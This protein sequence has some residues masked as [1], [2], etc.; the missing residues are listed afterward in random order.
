M[1]YF[2][3][4]AFCFA[5]V[6]PSRAQSSWI[7]CAQEAAKEFTANANKKVDYNEMIRR[8]QSLKTCLSGKPMPDF[9][10]TSLDG[11]IISPEDIKGKVVLV[12]F[13]FI[14]CAPCV[15]EIPM[16][17]EL[18]DEYKDC[19]FVIL[20]FSRDSK[21]AIDEF[22][23][24]TP[25]NFNVFASSSKLIENTFGVVN[26]YPT[27]ILLNKKGFLV[28]YSTGGAV[29][30]IGIARTKEKMRQLIEDQLADK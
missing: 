19:G 15:K 28:E 14:A 13:W 16:F 26:G 12:N 29:D 3:L 9:S 18:N 10:A 7:E 27:N 5:I 30:D 24:S 11:K 20:S 6:V 4:C 8:E 1:K 25:M 22:I 17:N 21:F 23:K 2:L